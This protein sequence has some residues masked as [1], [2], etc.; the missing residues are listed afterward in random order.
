MA[1]RN[2]GT[3]SWCGALATDLHHTPLLKSEGGTAVIPLCNECHRKH[4]MAQDDYRRWGLA[5]KQKLIDE[6]GEDG[7]RQY[8]ADLG[9]EGANNPKYSN[10]K[11]AWCQKGAQ[12]RWKKDNTE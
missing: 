12:V 9:R 11:K 5:L 1:R 2:K 8:Y 7:M 3:C 4:H 6:R 10:Q